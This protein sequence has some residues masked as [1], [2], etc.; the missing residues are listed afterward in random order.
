MQCTDCCSDG[1]MAKLAFVGI[2]VKDAV[3]LSL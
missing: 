1:E 3:L 2:L